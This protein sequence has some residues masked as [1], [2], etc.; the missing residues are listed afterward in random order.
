MNTP[1]QLLTAEQ[2]NLVQRSYGRLLG[3]T[4]FFDRFYEIFMS[5]D[6]DVAPRFKNT[7]MERQKHL[8]R[9]GV[10]LV[11]MYAQG[12]PAGE[13]GLE[14]IRETHGPK[15]P[16]NVPARLFV[17]WEASFLKTVEAFTPEPPEGLMPA[18]KAVIRQGVGYLTAVPA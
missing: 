15:G 9:H 12:N 18:W 11:I 13:S 2:L 3:H 8:I 7:D 1:Q 6:P 4:D 17:R 16:L 10:N 14:R 5:S